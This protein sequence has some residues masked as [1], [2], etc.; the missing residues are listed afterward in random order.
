MDCSTGKYIT[1]AFRILI[2]VVVPLEFEAQ[3]H[4]YP[5]TALSQ[6]DDPFPKTQTNQQRLLALLKSDIMT[7]S[8]HQYVLYIWECRSGRFLN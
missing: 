2:Q 3:L 1:R 8:Y 5:V 7:M 6:M 4:K